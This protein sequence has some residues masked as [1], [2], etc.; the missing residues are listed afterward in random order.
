LALLGIN[1]A[2]VECNCVL[3]FQ[4]TRAPAA[5]CFG[6]ILPNQRPAFASYLR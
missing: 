6:Q 3:Q 1:E 5:Q 2:L 4:K